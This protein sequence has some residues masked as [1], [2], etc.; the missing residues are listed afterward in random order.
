MSFFAYVPISAYDPD[1]ALIVVG[2]GTSLG[3]AA[4]MLIQVPALRKTG[5]K[6]EPIVDLH[7]PAIMETVKIAV[8]T[9]IYI[10][11][12]LVAFS[13]RNAF[14]LVAS[15]QGP[16]TLN[17]AWIWYQLPY[18]VVAVSLSSA[19]FTEMSD[20][21]AKNNWD[22]LRRGVNR[23]LRGTLFLIIPLA[24]MVFVLADPLI[25]L[26]HAGA[27][28]EQDVISV[29]LILRIWVVSLPFYSVVMYLYKAFA[30]IR[31]FMAFAVMNCVLVVLQCA[32]YALLCAPE[33]LALTGVP[34]ADFIYYVVGCV[35]SIA[36][37][38]HYI[39]KVDMSGF[40]G[41][42]I[43]VTIATVCGVF[44][45]GLMIIIAP[46]PVTTIG[47][48][49]VEIILGGVLGLAVTFG[50]CKL[51]RVDEMSIVTGLIAKLRH[52]GA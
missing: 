2:V 17:Y 49:L 15:D 27:F 39:G 25:Q 24:G 45:V 13:F 21:V 35:A 37:L 4:Q 3:V 34:I 38:H 1:L 11:A 14:S 29:G 9:L 46:V 20:A 36:L 12:N 28:T 51:L 8:P 48:A 18:G 32:L 33:T 5:F 40:V 23:G 52:R 6:W 30:S 42:V 41:M 7:D 43:R 44:A 31:K 50:V 26:F 47:P 22:G 10:T 16:S 19:M